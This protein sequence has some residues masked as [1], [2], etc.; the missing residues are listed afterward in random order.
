[1][2]LDENDTLIHF[3]NTSDPFTSHDF[4]LSKEKAV[5]SQLDEYDIIQGIEINIEGNNKKDTQFGSNVIE[6]FQKNGVKLN[7]DDQLLSLLLITHKKPSKSKENVIVG[8]HVMLLFVSGHRV[9]LIDLQ[10]YCNAK[11]KFVFQNLQDLDPIVHLKL[12]GQKIVSR[13]IFYG[14]Y[15]S[16]IENF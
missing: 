8:S 14:E 11:S 16:A 9:A 3:S 5:D 4:E 10:K 7:M 13:S 2:Y 6:L 1:M 12:I 15:E